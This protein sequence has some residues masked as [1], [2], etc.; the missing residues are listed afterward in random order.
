[1]S[2]STSGTTKPIDAG[3]RGPEELTG[4]VDLT[5]D[6]QGRVRARLL[7]LVLGRSGRA[8]ADWLTAR[9]ES[10]RKGVKIAALD[11]FQGYKTAIDDHSRAPSLSSAPS[12]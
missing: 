5:P 1:V 4:M 3:G 6:Q 10:F 7:D 11:S 8:Y 2:T 9:G 12:M